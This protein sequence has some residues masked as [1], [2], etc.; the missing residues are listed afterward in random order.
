MMASKSEN[1]PFHGGNVDDEFLENHENFID[2]FLAF[3][4]LYETYLTLTAL[5][6]YLA[7]N[8]E[9]GSIFLEA[10]KRFNQ[11]KDDNAMKKEVKILDL[12]TYHDLHM[13]INDLLCMIRVGLHAMPEEYRKSPNFEEILKQFM[14]TFRTRDDQLRKIGRKKES[15]KFHD[16][17]TLL[18]ILRN[19]YE[20]LIDEHERRITELK[21]EKDLQGLFKKR[22]EFKEL[23]EDIQRNKYE[24]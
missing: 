6:L 22:M 23:F 15:H 11:L 14:V 7:E 5:K 21:A 17:D 10:Q 12:V 16:Q 13:R 19:A 4:Q 24:I 1:D 2:V 3:S 20:T 9:I 18:D 8:R